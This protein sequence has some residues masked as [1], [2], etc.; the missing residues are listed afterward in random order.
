ML[1]GR[2]APLAVACST[3]VGFAV[4]AGA[5]IPAGNLVINPGA[6]DG[7]AATDDVHV[8]AP[9]FPWSTTPGFTQVAYGTAGFPSV[10]VAESIGGGKALFAG[11]PSNASSSA[12]QTVDV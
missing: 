9:D 10:Q 2:A 5:A 6:E 4:P 8:F 7:A 12:E 1:S 3:M 11:G